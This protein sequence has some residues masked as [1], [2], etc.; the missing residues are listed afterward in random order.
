MI[1][2]FRAYQVRMKYKI[3]ILSNKKLLAAIASSVVLQVAIVYVPIFQPVF[4]TTA[5][6]AFDWVEIVAAAFFLFVA[7]WVY[8]RITKDA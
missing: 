3:G 5:M 7:M 8:G 1:E 4:G 6:E 2:M